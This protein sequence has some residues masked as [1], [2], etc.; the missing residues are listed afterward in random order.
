LPARWGI[1]AI[2][3][4]SEGTLWAAS[5]L[6]GLFW[7][8]GDR[9]IEY[10]AVPELQHQAVYQMCPAKAGDLWVSTSEGF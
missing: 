6:H 4:D 5:V 1:T 7:K 3:T 10:T 9:F 2:A 8:N